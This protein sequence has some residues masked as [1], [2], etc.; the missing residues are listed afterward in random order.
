L[1]KSRNYFRA[2]HFQRGCVEVLLVHVA[3]RDDIFTEHL[4][5]VGSAAPATADDH[6]SQFIPRRLA[7]QDCR[8][9]EGAERGGLE[10]TAAGKMGDV[11]GWWGDVM[12]Y[13][14]KKV[15]FFGKN[16]KRIRRR[17]GSHI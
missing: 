17:R 7:A 10:E 1:R 12:S 15:N 5:H 13:M 8:E 16:D 4:R 11:H 3:E 2:G 14:G 6:E 9:G